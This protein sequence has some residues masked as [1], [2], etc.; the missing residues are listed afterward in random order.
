MDSCECSGTR[1][2][3]RL[4][5]SGAVRSLWAWENTAGG[6]DQDMSVGELLFKFTSETAVHISF[7]LRYG[8]GK[9]GLTVVALGGNLEG[10]GRGQR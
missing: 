10:M 6:E 9:R 3:L 7:D 2:L 1:S 8:L 5:C 4:G